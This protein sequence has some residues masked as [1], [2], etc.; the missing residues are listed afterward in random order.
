MII[1]NEFEARSKMENR[2]NKRRRLQ[3]GKIGYQLPCESCAQQ[4][5]VVTDKI[6][7]WR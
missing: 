4:R 1:L 2:G 6:L 7:S 5:E 3:G